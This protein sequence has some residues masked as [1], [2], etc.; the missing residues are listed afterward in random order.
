M[1]FW[2]FHFLTDGFFQLLDEFPQEWS[3]GSL[4]KT[5]YSLPNNTVAMWSCEFF[6]GILI[7]TAFLLYS[8]FH[9]SLAYLLLNKIAPLV[10]PRSD[11][12]MEEAVDTADK[13]TSNLG[14]EQ[15]IMSY[16]L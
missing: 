12:S 2:T 6:T 5:V 11:K 13:V 8:Y 1:L 14:N 15:T 9:C 4:K 3:F 16:A 7:K 10:I